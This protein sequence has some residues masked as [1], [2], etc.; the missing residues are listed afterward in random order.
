M[1]AVV[2]IVR[3]FDD[4]DVAHIYGPVDPVRDIEIINAE[5]L[6]ADLETVEKRIVK[7]ER[8]A[9]SGDTV[10]KKEF[11]ICHRVGESLGR[12]VAVRN[13]TMSEEEAD[14]LRDLNLLTNK[15]VLYVANVS[16]SVLKS[17]GIYVSVIEDIARAEGSKVV[18]ICGDMESEIAELEEDEKKE[19]LEDLGLEESGLQKLIKAGYELLDLITFYTTVGPELR[20]WT[21]KKGTKAPKGAGKI[22]GDMERGFIRAEI[23]TY[24]DF[25]ASGSITAAKESGRVRIEGKD[26]SIEDGTIVYFRFNV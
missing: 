17:E 9:K 14:V 5:L 26:Y 12:G 4:P 2:H 16:E 13:I 21:V 22:H 8:Q 15:K 25:I 18:A 19:F 1:D 23:V 6:L 10:Y 3:C 7:I 20:A 24:Q 11:D